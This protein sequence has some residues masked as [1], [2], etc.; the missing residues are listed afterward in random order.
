MVHANRPLNQSCN[1]YSYERPERHCRN[2]RPGDNS[3][4]GEVAYKEAGWDR[5]GQLVVPDVPAPG[6]GRIVTETRSR[7]TVIS[8]VQLTLKKSNCFLTQ[9]KTQNV[10]SAAEVSAQPFRSVNEDRT[11]PW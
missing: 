2:Q 1:G 7:E 5:A 10:T 3:L 4:E 6:K 11:G 9:M 8:L